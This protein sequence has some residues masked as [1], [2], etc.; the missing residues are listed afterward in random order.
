[1]FEIPITNCIPKERAIAK[2]PTNCDDEPGDAVCASDGNI[3]ANM[4]ELRML[5]CG[6][7]PSSASGSIV[8]VC[9]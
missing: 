5:N 4:C 3:Y 2:C 8:T 1:V 7:V 9:N 6:Y